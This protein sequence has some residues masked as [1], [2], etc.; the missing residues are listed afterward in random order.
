MV[1][2]IRQLAPGVAGRLP[3]VSDRMPPTRSTTEPAPQSPFA[4]KV[5]DVT[6]MP[7]SWVPR[8]SVKPMP[9]TATEFGLV[10]VNLRVVLLPRITGLGVNALVNVGSARTTRVS[11]AAA[12]ATV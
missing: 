8:L 5:G 1:T 11:V 4:G 7:A 3:P 6:V 9:V 12:V 10:I 2:S